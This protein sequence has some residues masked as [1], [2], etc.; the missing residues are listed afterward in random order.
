VVAIAWK[1]DDET[2]ITEIIKTN[3]LVTLFSEWTNKSFVSENKSYER[4]RGLEV[5]FTLLLARSTERKEQ[6]K[7]TADRSR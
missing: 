1:F 2:R 3:L 5:A 7:V 4:P 6:T